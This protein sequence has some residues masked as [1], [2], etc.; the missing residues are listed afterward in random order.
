MRPFLRKSES[1]KPEEGRAEVANPR[2]EAKDARSDLKASISSITDIEEEKEKELKEG[3]EKVLER[4]ERE[5]DQFG[6]IFV[7]LLGHSGFLFL[8]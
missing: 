1:S 4:V 8:L 2:E 5:S 3:F 6:L 7:L